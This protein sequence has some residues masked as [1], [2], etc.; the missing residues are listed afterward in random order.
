M[1]NY[2]MQ[3]V[4]YSEREA[5]RGVGWVRRGEDICYYQNHIKRKG[6]HYY[7]LTFSLEFPHDQDVV[8]VM[9]AGGG[10]WGDGRSS[11]TMATLFGAS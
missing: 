10:G 2:G 7:T 4:M 3:P 11:T 9:R 6:G 5:R 8:C 1:F